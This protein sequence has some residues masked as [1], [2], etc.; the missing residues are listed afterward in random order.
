MSRIS[1]YRTSGLCF[2]V[3]L[4][5]V[6][7]GGALIASIHQPNH[8]HLSVLP[9]EGVN[10][11]PEPGDVI[12]WSSYGQD[13]PPTITFSPF[14]SSPCRD[15][16]P[17]STCIYAGTRD[18]IY[19]YSCSGSAICDPGMGPSSGTKGGGGSGNKLAYVSGLQL[20][21]TALYKVDLPV[22]RVLGL[23]AE[24]AKPYV[25]FGPPSPQPFAGDGSADAEVN[26]DSSSNKIQI[27]NPSITKQ[28]GRS[29]YW[30]GNPSVSIAVDP[31]ICKGDMSSARAIQSCQVIKAAPATAYTITDAAC[32]A[33]PTLSTPTITTTP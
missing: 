23:V 6:V 31:S 13:N 9:Y 33:Q 24:P 2:L 19:T 15:K 5:G 12:D 17:G 1:V 22:D 8:I 7:V 30:L 28:V 20:L 16:T 3:F 4:I 27:D 25:P 18:N 21:A 11:S 29:I 32:T 10:V 26:C 14:T